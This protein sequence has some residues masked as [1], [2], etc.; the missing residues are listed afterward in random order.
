MKIPGVISTMIVATDQT[1]THLNVPVIHV[2]ILRE[3]SATGKKQGL[4]VQKF[5]LMFSCLLFYS[6]WPVYAKRD[7]NPVCCRTK[8]YP[9]F[10]VS[11]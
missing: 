4:Q 11:S 3:I 10:D 9:I 7:F 8:F 5:T 2:A 6:I 1:K